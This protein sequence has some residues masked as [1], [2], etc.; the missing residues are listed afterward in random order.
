MD[1]KL[2]NLSLI[3]DLSENDFKNPALTDM[4]ST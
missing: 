4:E 1:D 3:C 2:C